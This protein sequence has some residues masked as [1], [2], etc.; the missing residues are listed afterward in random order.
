MPSKTSYEDN[1]QNGNTINGETDISDLVQNNNN[2][3]LN[4]LPNTQTKFSLKNNPDNSSNSTINTSS[5]KRKRK[6]MKEDLSDNLK[7][8]KNENDTSN[9]NS[10]SNVIFD[11]CHRCQSKKIECNGA[12]PTCFACNELGFDCKYDNSTDNHSIYDEKNTGVLTN[13][14][15]NTLQETLRYTDIL[16]ARIK[17]LESHNRKLRAVCNLNEQNLQLIIDQNPNITINNVKLSDANKDEIINTTFNLDMVGSIKPTNKTNKSHICDGLCKHNNLHTKPVAT[18]FNLNDPTSISFEQNQAPGLMA[19]RAIN[20]ITKHNNSTQ[21]AILVSLSVPRSTEE[22]LVV[23]NLLNKIKRFFGFTSKQCLYTVTL[24]S[25]LKDDLP[26]PFTSNS[27]P[28]INSNIPPSPTSPP[29]LLLPAQPLSLL[30]PHSSDNINCLNHD[31]VSRLINDNVKNFDCLKNSNLWSINNLNEL[32]YDILKFNIFKPKVHTASDFSDNLIVSPLNFDDIDE[33]INL[34]FQHWADLIPIFN[35]REFRNHYK[36]FKDDIKLMNND[37]KNFTNNSATISTNNFLNIKFFACLLSVICLFGNL[38][39]YNDLKNIT[40]E[41]NSDDNIEFSG[42]FQLQKRILYFHK[43][44]YILPQNS[45]FNT[46]TTSIRIL[47]LLCLIEYYFLNIGDIVQLYNLRGTVVSMSQQLRLHRCPS[48]VLT[49]SGNKMNKLEQSNRRR[50]FWC[51]YYLDVFAS[52]QLGVPRLYKD[53]EIE[54]ALPLVREN[55]TGGTAVD[56]TSF[57]TDKKK[58]KSSKSSNIR[59]NSLNNIKLEGHLSSFSLAVI[60]FAKILGNIL[61]TVYKRNMTQLISEKVANIHEEALNSWKDGLDESLQFV[62]LV[63]G[64]LKTKNQ[65]HQKLNL[66]LLHWLAKCMIR[67]P[68]CTMSQYDTKSL[69]DSKQ[70]LFD[71]S[72]GLLVTFRALN[73]TYIALPVNTSRTIARFSLVNAKE[74]LEKMR[75]GKDFEETKTLLLQCVKDIEDSRKLDLPGIISWYTLK[76]LDVSINLLMETNDTSDENMENFLQMKKKYYNEILGKT[77][78]KHSQSTIN[79]VSS[80][81]NDKNIKTSHGTEMKNEGNIS[82]ELTKSDSGTNINDFGKVLNNLKNTSNND[83]INTKEFNQNAFAQA[84]NLDPILNTNIDRFSNTDLLSFFSNQISLNANTTD[85]HK[86]DNNKNKLANTQGGNLI[87]SVSQ[88]EPMKIKTKTS[89]QY[90]LE[91]DNHNSKSIPSLFLM[92]NNDFTGLSLDSI[93]SNNNTS[94]NFNLLSNSLN[95][96]SNCVNYVPDL[97]GIVDASLGLAP[98]LSEYGESTTDRSTTND[99]KINSPSPNDNYYIKKN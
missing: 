95:T 72:N 41:N 31:N 99:M 47:Q 65:T 6:K 12:K 87:N 30:L 1:F 54:C 97:G 58:S 4:Y 15:F 14:N 98:I 33:L 62:E 68:L 20:T 90:G 56:S 91:K 21:L 46:A 19:T 44:M 93:Y 24:L 29:S 27:V 78:L 8:R 34:F 10:K 81:K 88:N 50:L 76:M 49:G 89:V 96:D 82:K 67:L 7:K 42:F 3:L 35:E 66:I 43:L 86:I 69:L 37:L 74:S 17:D 60:R 32:L 51:T 18:S 23:P 92:N 25:S 36:I 57:T 73:K 83:L 85:V 40:N 13:D 70:T 84:L 39:K 26:I 48:A 45:F 77:K 2:K 5:R 75:K 52:L 11:I 64:T 53:H 61:D 28:L 63:D 94:I 71:T 59:R 16:E 79:K 38:V 55:E 9:K 22:I 80:D